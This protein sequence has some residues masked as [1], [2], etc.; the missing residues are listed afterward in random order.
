MGPAA[1]RVA[2]SL[3]GIGFSQPAFPVWS[4]TTA[5]PHELDALAEVLAEQVVSTVRFEES[6]VDMAESGIDSF[7]HIGPGDVTAGMAK[8]T[9]PDA[10]VHVVSSLADIPGV[11]D[12]IVT[13]G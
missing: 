11:V 9:V 10:A 13:M 5:R 12:S 2:A 6:L 1:D 7:V 4:N 3:E 8:R